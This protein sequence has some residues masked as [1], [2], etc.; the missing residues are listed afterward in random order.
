[1]GSGPSLPS[2]M[3]RHPRRSPQHHTRLLLRPHGMA[4]RPK[5][6]SGTCC[7]QCSTRTSSGPS[8][9]RTFL[10]R[11][12]NKGINWTCPIYMQIQCAHSREGK[13]PAFL[14]LTVTRTECKLSSGVH[15]LLKLVWLPSSNSIMV[16][17]LGFTCH[18]CSSSASCYRRRFR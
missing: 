1:M 5:A 8:L 14:A 7:V 3:D 9:L 13:P 11:S 16:C 12:R 15:F 18:W 17:L 6:P 2:Q 4:A 10:L